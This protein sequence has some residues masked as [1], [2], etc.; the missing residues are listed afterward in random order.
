[1]TG[2]CQC[3]AVRYEAD[4]EPIERALCHCT[5]CRGTTG[6]PALAWFT[7]TTAAFRYTAGEPRRYASSEEA[8]REFCG[9]C[10]TQ[11]TFAHRDYS[12]DR[13]DVTTGSL[14]A[15]EAAPPREHIWVRSR[16]GWM[17]DLHALP[18]HRSDDRH[19]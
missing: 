11:L 3:R 19:R 2:G 7:V 8:V 18:E 5:I 12:G 16:L 15:P 14:D 10:G 6:A 17:A 4:G 13:I 1:M 9:V